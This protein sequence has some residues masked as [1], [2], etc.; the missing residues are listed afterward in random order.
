MKLAVVIP[1]FKIHF[2][3]KTLISLES[4]TNQNFSVY[5]GNDASPEDPMEVINEFTEKLDINYFKFENNVGCRSLTE[6]WHRCL[7]KVD[8]VEWVMILGD[9]DVLDRNCISDFYS[10]VEEVEKRKI[11]VIRYA[12]LVIDSED[13][14]LSII[15]THPEI[16]NSVSFLF[17]KVSGKTRSSLSEYIFRRTEVQKKFKDFPVGWHSDD[18]ALLEI[19]DFKSIFTIN[20]SIVS[21]RLSDVNISGQKKLL[22]LKNKGSFKFYNYLLTKHGERFTNQQKEIFYKKCEKTVL[23]DKKNLS[24]FFQ[25]SITYLRDLKLYSYFSFLNSLLLSTLYADRH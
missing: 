5:I 12:S 13:N 9:D 4:Q 20:S 22:R 2:F 18:L 10:H 17:R 8:Q 3:R 23:N 24:L 7:N 6:Q 1:Y 16:E 21:V 25:L 19:S 14:P 15:Y 11:N